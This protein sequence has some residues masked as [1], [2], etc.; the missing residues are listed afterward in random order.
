MPRKTKKS[1]KSRRRTL[2]RLRRKG[3]GDSQALKIPDAAFG[4]GVGTPVDTGANY[5]L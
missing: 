5:N 4:R 1:K 2:R 3:G